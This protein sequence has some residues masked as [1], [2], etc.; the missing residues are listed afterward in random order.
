MT[1][2]I[3][4]TLQPNGTLKNKLNIT[5]ADK[6]AEAEYRITQARYIGASRYEIKDVSALNQIHE[7]LFGDIY[8]WAG[9][10]RPGDYHKG[11]TKFFPRKLFE[12]AIKD[13]NRK[14][15]HINEVDYKSDSVLAVDLADLLLEVNQ[16]HPFRE[17][18]RRTQRLF[19]IMLARQKGKTMH[20]SKVAPAY[21]D[22]MTA[23]KRDDNDLM[24]Q[25]IMKAF[26]R[27]I[28]YMS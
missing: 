18:N 14:I 22:Y 6:L 24:A 10:Y 1:D 16:F 5:D 7:Y 11:N 9:K 19:I 20:L 21:E 17:G 13:I 2:W 26:Q 12:N 3:K 27:A 8:D 4:Q 15:D 23:C 28:G 25:A